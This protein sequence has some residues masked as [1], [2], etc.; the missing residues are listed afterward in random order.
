MNDNLSFKEWYSQHP[1][2]TRIM[3]RDKI[4]SECGIASTDIFYNWYRG[5]TP[6]PPLA[7]KVIEKIACKK[8]F[9]QTS[10]S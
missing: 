3:I 5:R 8:I 6:I 9:N 10:Q 2:N 4:I 7:K 1:D